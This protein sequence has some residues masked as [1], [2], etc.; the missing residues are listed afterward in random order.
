M[1]LECYIFVFNFFNYDTR[2]PLYVK[3]YYVFVPVSRT[4]YFLKVII[5]YDREIQG[6][7]VEI[8]IIKIVRE[9]TKRA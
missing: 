9:Y 3:Y 7:G 5:I 1:A 6:G 8:Q 4:R 2:P